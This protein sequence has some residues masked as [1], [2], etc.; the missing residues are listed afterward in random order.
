MTHAAHPPAASPAQPPSPSLTLTGFKAHHPLGFL[1]ACGTLRAVTLQGWSDARLS[2]SSVTRGRSEQAPDSAAHAGERVAVLHSTRLDTDT[3]KAIDTLIAALAAQA[4]ADAAD[5]SE[6][7]TWL[8]WADKITAPASKNDNDR[9]EHR[10]LFQS[11]ACA[12]LTSDNAR[13]ADTFAALAS[14]ALHAI[15]L[16]CSLLDLTSGNQSLLK[17]VRDL[18]ASLALAASLPT[19][20]TKKQRDAHNAARTSFREALLGPWRYT[21][22][23]HSLGWDSSAQR[24]HALRNMVP[25]Q[26]KANRS[27][28]AAVFLASQALPF[29]PVFCSRGRARTTG[30]ARNRPARDAAS[31]RGRRTVGTSP[32]ADRDDFF[33]WPTWD[34]PISLDTLRALLAHTP[35]PRLAARGVVALYR[36]RRAKTGGSQGDYRVLAQPTLQTLS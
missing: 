11:I 19:S 10:Q 8:N 24:L 1:A 9:T 15:D 12:A 21:D 22:D 26:D 25:E 7:V 32:T 4:R 13:G 34:R 16:E 31:G 23:D 20:P 18:A 30:F 5:K 35:S 14:D 2:W 6:R 36:S 27:V 17:S 33:T 3:T 28:R 29:F